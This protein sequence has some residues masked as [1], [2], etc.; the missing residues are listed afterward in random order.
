M[1]ELGDLL[2]EFF[3]CKDI[4]LAEEMND[5]AKDARIM[6]RKTTIEIEKLMDKA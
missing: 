6:N 3:G 5:T 1:R 2:K 4:D